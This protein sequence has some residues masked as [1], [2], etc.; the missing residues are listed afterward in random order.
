MRKTF[1]RVAAASG[2]LIIAMSIAAAVSA[3]R[4]GDYWQ[5]QRDHYNQLSDAACTGDTNAFDQL[6]LAVHKDE[7]PVAKVSM[8]WLHVTDVCEYYDGDEAYASKLNAEAAREGYPIGQSNYASR[9]L[10]GLGVEK[11]LALADTYYRRCIDN[12]YGNA[13]AYYAEH[14][15]EGVHVTRS[16]EEARV[17]FR[18]AQELG[19]DPSVLT[20]VETVFTDIGESTTGSEPGTVQSDSWKYKDGEAFYEYYENGALS[21]VVA[22]GLDVETGAVYFAFLRTQTNR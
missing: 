16:L 10:Q 7:N 14:L 15:V 8:A 20:R 2:C 11:D 4:V 9:L 19:A 21:A 6:F 13:A 18:K 17:L 3:E 5:E 22:L 1:D 12:G